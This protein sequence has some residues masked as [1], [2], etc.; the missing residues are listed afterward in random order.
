MSPKLFL[1]IHAGI[2]DAF[3]NPHGTVIR[4]YTD[5]IIMSIC[6]KLLNKKH[7]VMEALARAQVQ[8]P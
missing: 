7:E 8:V 2:W 6:T 4:V 1:G 3:G 5:Q